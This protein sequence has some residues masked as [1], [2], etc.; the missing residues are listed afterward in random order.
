MKL[1]VINRSWV[2]L[3]SA[4]IFGALAV[5][6]VN[7]YVQQTILFEKAKLRPTEQMVEVVVA[8][9]DVKKG[10]VVSA[11]SMAVRSVPKAFITGMTIGAGQ[12]ANVEGARLNIDMRGGE[13]LLKTSLEGVDATTFAMRIAAGTRAMTIN[14]DDTN[15]IAGLVQPGDKIDL[16]YSIKANEQVLRNAGF[17]GDTVNLFM[18]AITVLATG[19]QVRPQA[20]DAVSQGTSAPRSFST[21]TVSVNPEQAKKL[22]LAQK[23]GSLYAILRNPQDKT[24]VDLPIGDIPNIFRDNSAVTAAPKSASVTATQD[25][26]DVYVGGRGGASLRQSPVG[27]SRNLGLGRDSADQG[28]PQFGVVDPQSPAAAIETLG[29]AQLGFIQQLLD[30]FKSGQ[31]LSKP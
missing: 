26:V 14:V 9:A 23:T 16:F 17:K 19:K 8:K 18:P 7:R 10:E 15:S 6:A 4:L 20:I 11:N 31:S 5:Y 22:M 25:A 29:P 28:L 30:S 12:F 1:A 3:I 27:A 24:P 21:I 13:M 2:V